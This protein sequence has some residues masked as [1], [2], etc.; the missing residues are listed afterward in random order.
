MHPGDRE[1]RRGI[2][3]GRDQRCRRKLEVT[4]LHEEVEERA[5]DL[6][7]GHGRERSVGR[8]WLAGVRTLRAPTPSSV[9]DRTSWSG[10]E[11]RSVAIAYRPYPTAPPTIQ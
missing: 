3:L 2:V 5:T 11:V 4:P 1:Q 10:H 7:R 6:V 9:R 8:G